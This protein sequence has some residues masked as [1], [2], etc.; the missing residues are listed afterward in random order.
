ML[1]KYNPQCDTCETDQGDRDQ[2]N[3]FWYSNN[4]QDWYHEL[5]PV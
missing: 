2:L 5:A 4:P 1:M 3:I